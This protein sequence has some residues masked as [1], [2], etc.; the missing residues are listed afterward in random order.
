[1]LEEGCSAE[2]KLAWSEW[3]D[4][5]LDAWE[6]SDA[7]FVGRMCVRR[8]SNW[9]F[10]QEYRIIIMRCT[11]GP[12][13]IPLLIHNCVDGFVDGSISMLRLPYDAALGE[14]TEV[15]I[16]HCLSAREAPN[17][18]EILQPR[19]SFAT[20][21]VSSFHNSFFFFLQQSH[22]VGFHEPQYISHHIITSK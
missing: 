4:R 10:G 7:I 1:M 9:A 12:M 21:T 17:S 19:S 8:E 6:G 11:E 20:T 15:G 3:V 22:L 14:A 18:K 13:L 2:D 16:R 5:L